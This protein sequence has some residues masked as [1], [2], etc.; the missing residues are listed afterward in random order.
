MG[1][2]YR[3]HLCCHLDNTS[4]RLAF[5]STST[6]LSGCSMPRPEELVPVSP[7][8][9][10]PRGLQLFH[11]QVNLTSKIVLAKCDFCL[12]LRSH[13]SSQECACKCTFDF[14]SEVTSPLKNTLANALLTFTHKSLRCD[15]HPIR[16]GLPLWHG[17]LSWCSRPAVVSLTLQPGATHPAAQ[18]AHCGLGFARGTVSAQILP[19][20]ATSPTGQG[21]TQ[22]FPI[23]FVAQVPVQLCPSL[24][25][26]ATLLK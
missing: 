20:G 26:D 7:C 8:S 25:P 17:F 1:Q 15:L 24:P 16:E 9:C 22:L 5:T 10:P 2:N 23:L 21:C 13:F 6:A 12:S 14:H 18:D 4:P 3:S 19:Q 11:S